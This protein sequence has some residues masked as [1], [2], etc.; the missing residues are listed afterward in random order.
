MKLQSFQRNL[1]RAVGKI[2]A[3]PERFGSDNWFNLWHA[4]VDMHAHGRESPAHRQA[5]LHALIRLHQKIRDEMASFRKPYQQFVLISQSDPGADAVYLHSK[6]PHTEFP[7]PLGNV[8]W[9]IRVPP[10]LS[11]HID[12]SKHRVGRFRNRNGRLVEYVLEDI[13]C[14]NS[15]QVRLPEQ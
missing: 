4:H 6:N 13:D 9:K 5:E 3:T 10:W 12:V 15:H 2:V 8:N 1:A 14:L 7:T 11:S